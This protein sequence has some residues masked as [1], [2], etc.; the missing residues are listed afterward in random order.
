MKSYKKYRTRSISWS[1]LLFIS[2]LALVAC[3]GRAQSATSM[4]WKCSTESAP[5]VDKPAVPLGEAVPVD[6]SVFRIFVNSTQTAQVIDGWGGCF[7]E[8]GWKA[9]QVLPAPAAKRC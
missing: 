9:M 1:S 2:A 5:W 6:K 4:Q 3:L 8:L 7:N